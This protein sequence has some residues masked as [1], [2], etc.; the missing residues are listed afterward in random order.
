[1]ERKPSVWTIGFDM[2]LLAA[3]YAVSLIHVPQLFRAR[4]DNKDK[5]LTQVCNLLLIF[6]LFYLKCYRG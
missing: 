5:Y 4:L 1:M 3:A 6:R 2:N